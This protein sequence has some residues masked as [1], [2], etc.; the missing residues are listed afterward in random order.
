MKSPSTKLLLITKARLHTVIT[1][2]KNFKLFKLIYKILL[3]LGVIQLFI[4]L[5]LLAGCK[6]PTQIQNINNV[7]YNPVEKYA[8]R[9]ESQSFVTFTEWY[10]VYS[11]DEYAEFLKNNNPSNFPYLEAVGQYW[12]SSCYIN[13]I[14]LSKYPINWEYQI[15]SMVIGWSFSVENLAKFGYE[16]TIGR[17]TELTM[18]EKTSED[19]FAQKVAQDY[20]TF[21]H[22]IPWYEYN[23]ATPIKQLWSL[24]NTQ[25]HNKIRKWERKIILTIDYGVK[26]VYGKILKTASQSAYGFDE[27]KLF[28]VVETPEAQNLQDIDDLQII[29]E[30]G[31]NRYLISITR[32]EVFTNVVKQLSDKNIKFI[33]IAGNDEILLSIII[34]DKIELK[35]KDALY[36]FNMP[37]VI[38]TQD[39]RAVLVTKVNTLLEIVKSL[40]KQGIKL[41]HVYDY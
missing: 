20:G 19:I 41:E 3:V 14:T 39:K 36:L 10:I 25:T 33:E 16:N 31:P 28:A 5:Y 12:S 24:P 18:T 22:T 27:L 23:F 21:V 29:S 38:R 2:I 6:T 15:S 13:K 1:K 32:Y 34:P 7:K 17:L 11:L 9:D 37:I 26:F 8:T 30:L 40:E 35:N 4:F